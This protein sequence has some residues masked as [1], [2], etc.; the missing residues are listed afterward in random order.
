MLTIVESYIKDD[1]DLT[2]V[3]YET[4]AEM[5]NEID[6]YILE[7]GKGNIESLDEISMHF[8]PTAAYQEHSMAN[9]WTDEYHK[10]AEKFD[11]IYEALKKY[12]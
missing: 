9:N 10:L 5:R 11:N 1:S 6:K 8:S 3:Y 4:P 12:A 7:L 2:W